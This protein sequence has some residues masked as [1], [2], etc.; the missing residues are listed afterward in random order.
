VAKLD[1]PIQ[2]F[3]QLLIDPLDINTTTF[4]RTKITAKALDKN[5]LLADVTN[6]VQW[7]VIPSD[8][9]SITP[10]GLFTSTGKTGTCAI[11]AIYEKEQIYTTV[12]VRFVP[13][14]GGWNMQMLLKELFGTK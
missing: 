6:Q 7:R 12:N 14:S 11:L 9:G 10:D 3:Q 1:E 5:G 4:T 8:F 13:S 2:I